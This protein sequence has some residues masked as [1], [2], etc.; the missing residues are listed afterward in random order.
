MRRFN[1][2]GMATPR[3]GMRGSAT[4]EGRVV[5]MRSFSRRALLLGAVAGMTGVGAGG[6]APTMPGGGCGV[7]AWP[8]ILGRPRL[9]ARPRVVTAPASGPGLHVLALG[10][11]PDVVLQVPGSTGAEPMR[12]VLTL[13]G[14]GGSGRGGL[15][16]LQSFAEDYRLLL[17]SPGSIDNTWDVI[18]GGWGAD[19]RRIDEALAAAFVSYPVDPTRLAISGFSDGASYALSLGLAN[20]DLFTHVIA[21]SPGFL[22]P[23]RRVGTPQV[24][25]SHGRA[26][27]VLP[28]DATTRCIGPG[29]RAEGVPTYVREFEGGHVVPAE[30]A[31]DAVRWFLG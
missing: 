27:P 21:F 16:P 8:W 30:I 17:L 9:N 31:E 13:H 4:S 20:G 6:C 10:R 12:L 5:R 24:Y 23:V 7:S 3:P 28:I 11:G 1:T 18:S 19:V 25:I 15:A 26:D 14:A 22:A 2:P 29:L